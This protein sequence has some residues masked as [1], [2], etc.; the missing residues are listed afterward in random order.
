L[1]PTSF[2]P[3][4][5]DETGTWNFHEGDDEALVHVEQ[6]I[7]IYFYYEIVQM[8]MNCQIEVPLN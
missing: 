7:I 6:F 2:Q 5:C 8:Q 1:D 3:P 4:L